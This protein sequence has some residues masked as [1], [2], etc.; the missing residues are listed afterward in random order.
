MGRI[1]LTFSHAIFRWESAT[2]ATAIGEAQVP[3][4]GAARPPPG[5]AGSRAAATRW[6]RPGHRSLVRWRFAGGTLESR[7]KPSMYCTGWW[8]FS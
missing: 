3:R 2:G 8:G 4:R 5:W 7:F 6:N 1:I